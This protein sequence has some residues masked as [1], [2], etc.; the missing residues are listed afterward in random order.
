MMILLNKSRK[1]QA[2]VTQ[3]QLES[4]ADLFSALN[5]VHDVVQIMQGSSLT[6]RH[7]FLLLMIFE[8]LLV[9]RHYVRSLQQMLRSL[10]MPKT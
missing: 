1:C 7:Y 6:Y 2:V 3:Q 5:Q 10:K 4:S 9:N 8:H